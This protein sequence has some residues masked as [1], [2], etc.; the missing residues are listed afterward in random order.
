[1][2]MMDDPAPTPLPLRATARRVDR[3]CYGQR[4]GNLGGGDIPGEWGTINSDDR[5]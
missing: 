3:G 5:D 2:S 1:M 4:H